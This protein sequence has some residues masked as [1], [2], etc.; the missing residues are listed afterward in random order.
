MKSTTCLHVAD[1]SQH[2][3]L[4][5]EASSSSRWKQTQR[6]TARHQA[7]LRHQNARQNGDGPAQHRKLKGK[8]QMLA[9][10]NTAL[11]SRS[12]T[13]E[14]EDQKDKNSAHFVGTERIRRT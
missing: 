12:Q 4:S 3:C 10:T 2:N 13:E 14:I 11:S 1:R 5:R 6:P 7:E 9:L 8:G